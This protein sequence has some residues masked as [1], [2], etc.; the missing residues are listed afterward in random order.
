MY[1]AL[2]LCRYLFPTFEND[3]FLCGLDE[4]Q[5]DDEEASDS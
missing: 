3:M 1:L 2:P 4:E 5:S